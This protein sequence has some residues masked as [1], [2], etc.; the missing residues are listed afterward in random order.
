VPVHAGAAA[1][2]QDRAGAALA[3]GGVDGPADRGW[4]WDQDDLAAFAGDAQDPV[5]VFLAEIGDVAPAGFEDPQPTMP[6]RPRTP[7]RGG[8]G[9]GNASRSRT[10][11]GQP[12]YGTCKRR[13]IGGRSGCVAPRECRKLPI[14]VVRVRM[15]S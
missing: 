2:E 7:W 13:T 14:A 10:A 11:G 3:D 5:A 4:Q 1:V 9:S 6:S 8:N 12:S 15:Q